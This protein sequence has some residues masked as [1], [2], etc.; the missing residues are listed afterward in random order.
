VGA[1]VARDPCSDAHEFEDLALAWAEQDFLERR[2]EL[3]AGDCSVHEA[4]EWATVG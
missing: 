2:A 1:P 3:L 4:V